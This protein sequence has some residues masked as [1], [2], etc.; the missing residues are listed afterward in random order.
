MNFIYKIICSILII[1]NFSNFNVLEAANYYQYIPL[2]VTIFKVHSP[3]IDLNNVHNIANIFSE[4][5]FNI[6]SIL[7][8]HNQINIAVH[9][10]IQNGNIVDY[11]NLNSIRMSEL[12][13]YKENFVSVLSSNYYIYVNNSATLST[14]SDDLCHQHFK[15]AIYSSNV[16]LVNSILRCSLQRAQDNTNAMQSGSNRITY[17]PYNSKRQMFN[18]LIQSFT[19]MNNSITQSISYLNNCLSYLQQY[20]DYHSNPNVVNL[21]Y[22]MKDIINQVLNYLY[23]EQDCLNKLQY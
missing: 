18:Y 2:P 3:G 6:H 4:M 11:N 7:N 22:Q 1:A 12:W 20:F 23:A 14:A 8:Y 10:F 21:S 15:N 5:L 9:A 19:D 17:A 13:K 16:G